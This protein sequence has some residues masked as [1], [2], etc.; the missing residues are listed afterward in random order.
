MKFDNKMF[1]LLVL[2]LVGTALLVLGAIGHFGGSGS[3]LP[4]ALRFPG[5]NFV[6]ISAGVALIVP[7]MTYVINQGRQQRG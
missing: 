2:D 3:L 4:E 7:Y 6:L 5:H 1:L